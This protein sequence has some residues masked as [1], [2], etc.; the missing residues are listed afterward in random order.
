LDV[1][2]RVVPVDTSL[3]QC[4]PS[5]SSIQDHQNSKHTLQFLVWTQINSQT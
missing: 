3:M 1:S 5:Y 4:T 2:G